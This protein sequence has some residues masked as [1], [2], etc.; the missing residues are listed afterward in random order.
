M[1]IQFIDSWTKREWYLWQ[2][3]KHLKQLI[4]ELE[5]EN[6]S[7]KESLSVFGIKTK[8]PR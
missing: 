7:L 6:Q 1:K 3:N 5:R 8:I 2:R 4:S